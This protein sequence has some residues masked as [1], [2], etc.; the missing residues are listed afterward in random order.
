MREPASST[1][2]DR[3]LI[4]LLARMCLEVLQASAE[5][6]ASTAG[7]DVRGSGGNPARGPDAQPRAAVRHA[8]DPTEVQPKRQVARLTRRCA[9]DRSDEMAESAGEQRDSIRAGAYL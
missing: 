2:L 1:P 9:T 3:H 5:T 8:I 4:V 6:P 7:Q